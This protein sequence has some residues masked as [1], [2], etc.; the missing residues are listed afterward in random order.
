MSNLQTIDGRISLLRSKNSAQDVLAEI[1]KLDVSSYSRMSNDDK[2]LLHIG[3]QRLRELKSDDPFDW[4][5]KSNPKI[6]ALEK[7]YTQEKQWLL[8]ASHR[9]LVD[10]KVR[11]DATNRSEWKSSSFWSSQS[12]IERAQ[13]V[14]MIF[15]DFTWDIDRTNINSLVYALSR[16]DKSALTQAFNEWDGL[17]GT[18]FVTIENLLVWAGYIPDGH[19]DTTEMKQ[20]RS[21]FEYIGDNNDKKARLNALATYTG[22]WKDVEQ[23]RKDMEVASK[24]DS[25]GVLS[26][27]ADRDASGIVSVDAQGIVT[28]ATLLDVLGKAQSA[29]EFSKQVVKLMQSGGATTEQIQD[30]KDVGTLVT[31]LNK[32]PLLKAQF[33]KG[34][35][36]VWAGLS[37]FLRGEGA[38]NKY[39]ESRR[40]K[41]DMIRTAV[42][43]E[44]TSWKIVDGLEKKIASAKDPEKKQYQAMLDAFKASEG[45]IL[46]QLRYEWTSILLG[47]V[48]GNWLLGAGGTL[49][50]WWLFNFD[51]GLTTIDGKIVPGI[52][53]HKTISKQIS[54]NT[55]GSLTVGVMNIVPYLAAGI[56]ITKYG[57]V[58]TASMLDATAKSYGLSV[59]VS[60]VAWGVAASYRES[61][62]ETISNNEKELRSILAQFIEI[63]KI[64]DID[65]LNLNKE[66][67]DDKKISDVDVKLIKDTIKNDLT[68]FGMESLPR[69]LESYVTTLRQSQ[70]QNAAKNGYE[71]SGGT[72]GVQ[73]V[74]GFFPIPVIGASWE[75]ISLKYGKDSTS[76]AIDAARRLDPTSAY[77]VTQPEFEGLLR[78]ELRDPTATITKNADGSLTFKKPDHLNIYGDRTLATEIDGNITIKP[79]TS[80]RTWDRT[81]AKNAELSIFLEKASVTLDV[82]QINNALQNTWVVASVK[83]DNIEFKKDSSVLSTVSIKWQE[84]SVTKESDRAVKIVSKASSNSD[85]PT[86]VKV[87][88]VT[89]PENID[90]KMNLDVT[91]MSQI[92][93]SIYK[94]NVQKA[95]IAL[96][97]SDG[98]KF[99]GYRDA[100]A[101]LMKNPGNTTKIND[102]KNALDAL[103]KENPRSL[104]ALGA[105]IEAYNDNTAQLE[106]A[107]LRTYDLTLGSRESREIA[108]LAY[109]NSDHTEATIKY[110]SYANK[111]APQFAAIWNEAWAPINMVAALRL[112]KNE[113]LTPSTLLDQLWDEAHGIV[114]FNT[115]AQLNSSGKQAMRGL[116][117]FAGNAPILWKVKP[118]DTTESWTVIARIVDS[119]QLGTLPKDITKDVYKA[120][121]KWDT[122]AKQKIEDA[123]YKI[124]GKTNAYIA[125]SGVPG[126]ECTNPLVFITQP[127]LTKNGD[128]KEIIATVSTNNSVTFR[129]AT[130]N[131]A[132]IPKLDVDR[133]ALGLMSAR[134][135]TETV[136]W[137]TETRIDPRD[138]EVSSAN[139]TEVGGQ[140]VLQVT[141]GGTN[142]NI[143]MNSLTRDQYIAIVTGKSITIS[144]NVTTIINLPDVTKNLGLTKDVTNMVLTMNAHLINFENLSALETKAATEYDRWK[145]G[146]YAK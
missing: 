75:K 72:L 79:G 84:V 130:G 25:N 38:Y 89:K 21:L 9:V 27:L 47:N 109:S 83:D 2:K 39:I 60:P 108:R 31:A 8:D 78:H 134:S 73:F 87:I 86:T 15:V 137:W 133:V 131:E 82:A 136:V 22:S 104:P 30:I 102:A 94:T 34:V 142:I 43:T 64:N 58:S 122:S 55:R 29:K 65:I 48:D 127:R 96:R 112:E 99:R 52:G 118:L 144:V 114:G 41:Y 91:V 53:I 14:K 128:S 54:E 113:E 49:D 106:F 141:S 107:L 63:K 88:T 97:G 68:V 18:G 124:D 46:S 56:D 61:M 116:I 103:I 77:S 119:M 50:V 23:A 5:D 1:I 71:L 93:K 6:Q 101:W 146:K 70:I 7:L 132:Y 69:V 24:I 139:I 145:A 105:A 140:Q 95:M 37:S 11:T 135:R 35:D 28:E 32:N 67:L 110:L 16:V 20:I 125:R 117:P 123:W 80:I 13:S 10:A 26:Y 12:N 42:D 62:A 3:L 81:D 126:A 121:L 57:K 115:L 66:R 40:S 129:A 4:I 19:F 51:F 59:N 85:T 92:T 98:V 138:V 90:I 111:L 17:G 120:M 74:A 76:A 143:A 36:K 100:I 45:S 33:L 44:I